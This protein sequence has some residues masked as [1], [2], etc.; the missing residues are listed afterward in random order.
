MRVVKAPHGAPKTRRLV[1][2]GE[3]VAMTGATKG[4][5]RAWIRAK[6]FP[7]PVSRG[8]GRGKQHQWDRDAVEKALTGRWV[9]RPRAGGPRP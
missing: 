4:T 7:P 8:G 1:S 2:F 6:R 3:I 5:V 9:V